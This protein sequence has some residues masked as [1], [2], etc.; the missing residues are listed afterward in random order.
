[1]NGADTSVDLVRQSPV[2][3]GDPALAPLTG[4][5]AGIT[6]V[7][8]PAVSSP[9]PVEPPNVKPGPTAGEV[10]AG[11]MGRLQHEQDVTLSDIKIREAGVEKLE[12]KTGERREKE[13]AQF[14]EK[15]HA[16]M[17]ELEDFPPFKPTQLPDWMPKPLVNG[18]GF[19]KLSTSMIAMALIGGILSRGNWLGAGE[20]LNGAMQGY[21]DGNLARAKKDFQDYQTQYQKALDQDR[22]RHQEYLDV[23]ENKKLTINEMLQEIQIKGAR[24]RAEDLIAASKA[25]SIDGL[26]HQLAARESAMSRIAMEQAKFDQQFGSSI[27]GFGAGTEGLKGMFLAGVPLSQVYPGWGNNPQRISAEIAWIH[28]LAKQLNVTDAEAGR[29]IVRRQLNLSGSK[30]SVALQY[31]MLGGAYPTLAQLDFNIDQ[32]EK[33]LK[34]ERFRSS[35]MSPIFNAI[36]RK[37]E[38]WT[39]DPHLV[40]LFYYAQGVA[41]EAARLQ[42]GAQASVQ[43]LHEG[44]A[45]RAQQWANTNLTP[46]QFVDV[47]H[48]IQSEGRARLK[49]IQDSI[50]AITA[51]GTGGGPEETPM[52]E[53]T[54]SAPTGG[55]D[56]NTLPP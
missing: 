39:G 36:I 48:A 9:A 56:W 16:K 25:R 13:Y 10:L 42:Q 52:P 17:K 53:I 18:D 31:R 28:D 30:S 5:L 49:Y 24:D 11:Q 32:S 22:Q 20:M 8:G 3:L 33:I 2:V 6:P 35:D 21:L 47:A 46:T 4:P 37:E 29:E 55:L 45:A 1:M 23:L 27:A 26:Y 50:G 40:G 19:Q 12:E 41:M 54:P 34:D 44:A 14:E 38:Y 7:P 51:T 15:I 43:Q